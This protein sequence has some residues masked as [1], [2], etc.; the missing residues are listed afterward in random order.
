MSYI[1]YLS[2]EIAI[3]PPIPW[4]DL[5]GSPFIRTPDRNEW[6]RLV[7]LRLVEEPFE[8]DEGTFIRRVAV[9][10][11]PSEGDELRAYSLVQ[12]VQEILDAHSKGRACTGHILVRGERSPDI[13]RVRA[14]GHNA[15]DERPTMLWPDG[16]TVGL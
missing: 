10:I 16:T 6:D 2:G 9:A 11:R 1:S 3:H 5:Q 12:E 4:A 7:W 15:I 14:E 13:W 8:T